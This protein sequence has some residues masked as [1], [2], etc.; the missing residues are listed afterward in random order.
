MT[1]WREQ[2]DRAV[3]AHAAAL[4]SKR[5]AEAAQARRLIAD[6]LRQAPAPE[7]LTCLS[8]NGRT[9]YRTGLMGWYLNTGRTVAVDTSGEYYVLLVPQSFRARFTGVTPR[10]QQPPLIVGEGARDGESIPLRTLLN[11]ILSR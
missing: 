11:N 9:R 8:Y 7:P 5:E 1:D 6:F 2:R 4:A 10:P 3:A